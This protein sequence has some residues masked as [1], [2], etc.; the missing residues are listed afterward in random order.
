M[1]AKKQREY[2]KLLA[3]GALDAAEREVERYLERHP[4]DYD[5]LVALSAF[6]WRSGQLEDSRALMGAAAALGPRCVTGSHDPSKPSILKF[7]SFEQNHFVIVE[8]RDGKHY[9]SLYCGHFATEHLLADTGRWNRYTADLHGRGFLERDAEHPWSLFINSISDPDRGGAALDVLAEYLRRHPDVPVINRPD[10]VALTSRDSNH[11]ALQGIEGLISPNT[12]RFR[13]DETNAKLLAGL[14]AAR[15]FA[16]PV[17]LR[18]VGTQTGQ[19]VTLITDAD[20]LER[21]LAEA[22]PGKEHYAIQ[23]FDTRGPEGRHHKTRVFFVDGRMYPVA[24]L[25]SDAWEIHSN[26]RYRIMDKE[27]WTRRREEAFLNDPEAFLG[28]ATLRRLEAIRDALGLDFF[29]IDFTKLEDGRLLVFEAN[30]A[31]RHNFD[32][33]DNFPYT[34]PHLERVTQAFTRMVEERLQAYERRQRSYAPS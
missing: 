3:S 14:L 15:G 22:M 9:T 11:R 16:T 20:Q 23:Y 10:R 4:D 13:S 19:T 31:M 24:A 12:V 7:R 25:S 2:R 26:D 27:A 30:G 18:Q 21:Y 5:A 8:G 6:R 28:T 17:I 33:A 1:A 34:R 29:G 32:H